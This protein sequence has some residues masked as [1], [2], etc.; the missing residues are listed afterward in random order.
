MA[1]VWAVDADPLILEAIAAF[2]QW[3]WS[4]AV[5]FLRASGYADSF[6]SKTIMEA[7]S[8]AHGSILLAL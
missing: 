5:A 7:F 2:E 8:G 1:S 4:M 3:W 6:M